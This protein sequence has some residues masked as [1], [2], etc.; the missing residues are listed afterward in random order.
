MVP[1]LGIGDGGDEVAVALPVA[2]LHGALRRSLEQRHHAEA[3][4]RASSRLREATEGSDEG[5]MG[6]AGDGPEPHRP[7]LV[8]GSRGMHAAAS[9]GVEA[10]LR[11]MRDMYSN[12]PD[13]G[14]RGS[15]EVRGGA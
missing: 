7:D 14:H 8:P 1:E 5:E 10:A 2:R 13:R 12:R 4:A 6:S 3:E 9:S 11:V 15:D